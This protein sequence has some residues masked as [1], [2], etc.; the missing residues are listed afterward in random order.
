MTG[1]FVVNYLKKNL[2]LNQDQEQIVIF[3]TQLI[4]STVSSIG[5]IVL[6]A[7]LLGNL[8]ETVI[9]LAAAAALRLAAGGAHCNTALRCTLA[10]AVIFPTLGLIPQYFQV[11]SY[12]VILV[13]IIASLI[14]IAKYAPAEA[15]GKPLNNQEYIKKMYRISLSLVVLIAVLALFLFPTK[16]NVSTGL[17]TGLAW[18]A[19][20][21]TSLGY[22]LIL[23]L[24]KLIYLIIRR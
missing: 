6:V 23:G 16:S 19:F 4:E 15:P 5:A 24:D 8:Q 21:I 7:F 20:N 18:Q 2:V 3:A 11:D 17:V 14:S 12:W 9:V 22:K 1:K 10:G 13:P